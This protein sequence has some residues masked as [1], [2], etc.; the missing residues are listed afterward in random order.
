M[1]S[2]NRLSVLYVLESDPESGNSPAFI[3]SYI[4]TII[5]LLSTEV[6]LTVFYPEFS[7]SEEQ[8]SLNITQTP[9]FTRMISYLPA[10]HESFRETF[11]NKKME[12][13]FNYILKDEH[14]DCIHIWSLKNHSFNY[15]FIA[16]ERGL[17]VIITVAD[18]FLFSNSIF[19]KGF[20]VEEE[21]E[22]V[23]ISNFVNSSVALFLKKIFL[24]AKSDTTRSRW[25]ENI[26]RY[27]SYYNR[28]SADTVESA[29]FEE[30]TALTDETIKF[31]DLFHF[32]SELEYNLFYRS[33]IPET[34]VFFLEQNTATDSSYSNRPFEIEGAVKFGFMGE[35]LPEEGVL[36]LIEAFNI[37]Y[38]EGYRNELHLYG[39]LHE[40]SHYSRRLEKKVRNSGVFFH[41]PVQPG[42]ISS[43]LNTID[44]LIIP[45]KWHR[46]DSFLVNTA[47]SGRKAII[48]SDRNNISEKVRRSNR[49]LV[50]N[51]VTASNIANA[52]SEL[53]RNRK[54]L[55][56]FM[57]TTDDFIRS[58][59]E[60][61]LCNLLGTYTAHSKKHMEFD[62]VLLKRTL[63]KKK[64]DRQRG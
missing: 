47:I 62:R 36:E 10:R 40:N 27:S 44:V 51:Q 14:F 12:D 17:P 8:Y 39:E 1:D 54:R 24:A 2:E 48:V 59:I 53:E 46:S 13:I 42:R 35:I 56:Y 50:L 7:D 26:G 23:R 37:L 25:F 30:R 21:K 31:T 58:D 57:R 22:R 3:N 33:I 16:K 52:V 43:A 41:G 55:Y 5:D 4:D 6:D 61:D 45:A 9:K 18:G 64:L 49:G 15:P 29:I 20:F 28:T 19:R 38:D 11:A 32:F 60:D 63:V 34:K